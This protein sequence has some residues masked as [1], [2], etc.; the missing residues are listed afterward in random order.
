MEARSQKKRS[1]KKKRTKMG[2]KEWPPA[3][4]S[5]QS[6][7]RW[8]LVPFCYYLLLAPGFWLLGYGLAG[9]AATG[10]AAS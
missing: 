1:Q 5:K 10:Y 8:D 9:A 4:N 7:D 2:S 6:V 3:I